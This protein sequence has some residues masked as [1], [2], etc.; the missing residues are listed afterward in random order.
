[1]VDRTL[2]PDDEAARIAA[3]RRYEILD[4]PADG[5]FDRI[6]ALAAKRFDAPIS[7]VSIVDS[8][9]IWFK[10]HHGIDAEQVGRDPG[11]CASAILGDVPWVVENAGIDPR[12]LANPLVA[13]ELGLRFY[14]GAPLITSDG[15]GLGTLCVIDRD[16]RTFTDDDAAVLAE[17][18]ALVVDALELRLAARRTVRHEVA[19][20]DQAERTARAL[21]S[22]LLPLELPPIAGAR[23]AALYVPADA[24]VVGGDFYDAFELADGGCALV[25]GDVSGKGASAA[26]VTALA[27]HTLRTASL[28]TRSRRGGRRHPAGGQR[29]GRPVGPD[30]HGLDGVRMLMNLDLRSRAEGW[31]LAITRPQ[32]AVA[33]LLRLSGFAER[34]AIDGEGG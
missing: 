24:G 25:V 1:M 11:L 9:R 4:T 12:T 22:S 31:S 18:A 8:D 29:R 19:L 17:M 7:I 30:L 21:Q 27:R 13:G 6:T 26:A 10:S 14:A 33:R 3:V 32:P 23:L 15:H 34:V 5:T 2:I 28:S 20:R 16:P